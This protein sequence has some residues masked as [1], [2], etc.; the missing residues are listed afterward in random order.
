MNSQNYNDMYYTEDDTTYSPATNQR[1]KVD[2]YNT[3]VE[4]SKVQTQNS[5]VP[6]NNNYYS[7]P[8]SNQQ[9]D[10]ITRV[11]SN[12][13]PETLKND[14][15]LP[16][17]LSNNIGRWV[18]A[19]FLIGNNIE[20]EVGI[21]MEVGASYIVLKSLEPDTIIVCDMFSIKFITI[22]YGDD[23]EKLYHR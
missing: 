12:N 8:F 22:I 4:N 11:G 2:M 6:N 15:Y 7:V 23:F 5:L 14:S 18:R 9:N 3:K 17:Y 10:I 19:N 20:E 1:K 21:L 16:A 13:I